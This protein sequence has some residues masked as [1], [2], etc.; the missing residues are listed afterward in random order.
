MY[1]YI[2]I[3]HWKQSQCV[4]NSD[5]D[6]QWLLLSRVVVLGLCWWQSYTQSQHRI[7]VTWVPVL[8]NSK[9]DYCRSCPSQ[10]RSSGMWRSEWSGRSHSRTERWTNSWAW[11]VQ[12]FRWRF[13]AVVRAENVNVTWS[14][15]GI[16]NFQAL[17]R[18]GWSIQKF[19]LIESMLKE[20]SRVT[21]SMPIDSQSDRQEAIGE[22]QLLAISLKLWMPQTKTGFCLQHFAANVP[23]EICQVCMSCC[24]LGRYHNDHNETTPRYFGLGA[25]C[26]KQRLGLLY[27]VYSRIQ[28]HVSC[29]TCLQFSLFLGSLVSVL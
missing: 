2:Y 8:R 27:A 19:I 16:A 18:T 13:G 24:K 9:W 21:G 1:I 15:P 4:L 23:V 10:N 3:R 20:S 7:W 12:G 5:S 25:S 17:S 14:S 26:M 22:H 28:P 11:R 29:T 6:C